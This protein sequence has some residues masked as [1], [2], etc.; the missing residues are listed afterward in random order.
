MKNL[1]NWILIGLLILGCLVLYESVLSPDGRTTLAWTAP[2]E[3]ENN[4]PLIDLAG[5]IIHCWS[6]TGKYT[7]TIYIDDPSTTSHEVENLWPGTYFCA[8]TGINEDGDES[9]LSNVVA[10][11]VP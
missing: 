7:S 11:M 2:T 3:N 8:V 5:F 4:E 6:E 9:A 10:K 1:P